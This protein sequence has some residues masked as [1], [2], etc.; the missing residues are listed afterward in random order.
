[1]TTENPSPMS[2]RDIEEDSSDVSQSAQLPTEKGPQNHT[3]LRRTLNERHVNM[4]AFS[5]TIGIGLFLQSGKVMYLIGPGGAVLAYLLMGS[6]L[7]AANGS[8]GEMTAVF[9]VKGSIIDFPSRFLDEGVGFAVGWMAWFAYIIL[10]ATEVSTVASLFKFQF[11]PEYLQSFNYPRETLQWSFGLETNSAVWVGLALL[12]ILLINLLPV[13]VYGEIEYVC[14]CMKMVVIVSIILFNVIVSAQRTGQQGTHAFQF[15]QQPWGFF[16]NS[17]HTDPGARNY[18]FTG[19]TGRLIGFWSAL[20]TI[21]FSVQGFF[22]VSVTAAENKH[23]DKDES[24][25][26]AT[27]KIALRVILLYALVVFTVGLNVPYNDVNLQDS[28]IS[29]IRRGQNSPIIITCVRNGVVGWPHFLNAF[30]IFSAFSTGVNG[31]YISSR[32]LHALASVRN[33]WPNTGWGA[34]VKGWLER[35][36]AK[37]VP[38]NAVLISWLFGFL[39]FLAVRPFPAKVQKPTLDKWQ[40][41]TINI[42][43]SRPPRHFLDELYA[44]CVYLCISS[45]SHVQIEVHRTTKGFATE[46]VVVQRNGQDVLNRA[47]SDYPY[48]SHFQGL[49]SV[50]ALFGCCLFIIFNGWRSFLNP[51]STADFLA[52]YMSIPIFVIIVTLYHIKDEAETWKFW[53]WGFQK[54]MDI[55]NPI[56][57]REKDPEKRKGRLH[58]VDKTKIFGKQNAMKVLEVIWT[59]LK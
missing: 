17:T 11:T 27:R 57:T 15:Y 41:L 34:R 23:V 32:L 37:G 56:I 45:I 39:G 20:N 19:D 59:W 29:S 26:L 47:A 10:T 24:I 13:R 49:R 36:S 6:L 1:M 40:L 55:A 8:L 28:S 51:F 25:K 22:T 44:D 53:C 33:V 42:V 35:T 58:R 7:W 9:P 2:G 54:S 5:S 48:R 30:Y 4:I 38:I 16:S 21:F 12:G 46:P 18:T 31:L 14:G 50:Y 52:A 43:D 3:E